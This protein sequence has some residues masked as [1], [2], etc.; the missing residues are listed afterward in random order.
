MYRSKKASQKMGVKNLN[1]LLLDKCSK[2]AIYKIGL[3]NL[4]DKTVVV[5]T[6]IYMYK[7]LAENALLENMYLFISI[8]KQYNIRPIFIF[9]GKPPPEKA[10]LLKE[11]YNDKKQAQTK[12]ADLEKVL[13]DATT[14]DAK[15]KRELA[16]EM[17]ALKKRFQRVK[18]EDVRVVKQL[19][20][21]YGVEY[22]VSAGEADELC[23]AFVKYGKAWAC[24]TDDMDMF[25]YDCPYVIRNVSLMNHTAHIY[26]KAAILT[27]M[28][29]TANEFKEIIILS[30]TDYSVA[31]NETNLYNTMKLFSEY[32]QYK[33]TKN[34]TKTE[35]TKTTIGFYIWL[36]KNTKYI[37]NYCELLK[38]YKMYM[39]NET[40]IQNV[41]IW[42][43]NNQNEQK[44]NN[45]PS[46]NMISLMSENGFVFL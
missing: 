20:D 41:H 12:Y 6:S 29:M 28:G 17:Q 26:D 30:G 33:T 9:D 22:H 39:I 8:L 14:T 25:I 35:T 44:N 15:L 31:N 32:K 34:N 27:E 18:N 1:K 38:V 37:S 42:E 10:D 4:Q 45:K 13:N 23:A 40:L 43:N 7:F 24:I 46:A 3:A 16:A 36:L 21:V 5:D 11:R 2:A 19:M